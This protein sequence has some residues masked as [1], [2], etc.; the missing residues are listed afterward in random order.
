MLLAAL[1]LGMLQRYLI[2]RGQNLVVGLAFLYRRPT[3]PINRSI[4]HYM[5]LM[6]ESACWLVEVGREEKARYI[7]G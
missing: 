6:P 1:R 3:G 7:L 4:L 2:L 5:W